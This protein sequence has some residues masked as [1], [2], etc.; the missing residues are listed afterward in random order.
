MVQNGMTQPPLPWKAG[1]GPP[2]S[3]SENCLKAESLGVARVIYGIRNCTDKLIEWKNGRTLKAGG[4]MLGLI[5]KTAAFPI[6]K[7]VNTDPVVLL[8]RSHRQISAMPTAGKQ[9][10]RIVSISCATFRIE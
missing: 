3:P 8:S 5:L 4:I 7:I 1:V 10:K 9:R 6:L 2:T